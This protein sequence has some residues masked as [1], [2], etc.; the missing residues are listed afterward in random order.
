MQVRID[1]DIKNNSFV[2]DQCAV[3]LNAMFKAIL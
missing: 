1:E 2:S 3:Q